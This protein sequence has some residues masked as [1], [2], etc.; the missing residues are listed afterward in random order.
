MPTEIYSE[1]V[2]RLERYRS[3]SRIQEELNATLHNSGEGETDY[4]DWGAGCE[5]FL[6]DNL[7][8][9]KEWM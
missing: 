1:A 3:D 4:A 5:R 6:E 7:G 8:V 2:S 9:L